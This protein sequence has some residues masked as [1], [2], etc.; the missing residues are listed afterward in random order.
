MTITTTDHHGGR[1]PGQF[2][3]LL[4]VCEGKTE[5]WG[6]LAG[7]SDGGKFFDSQLFAGMKHTQSYRYAAFDDDG[8]GVGWE[9]TQTLTLAQ[10]SSS[11]A[12][13]IW[14]RVVNNPALP[15]ENKNKQ[16]Y[17]F[18]VGEFVRIDAGCFDPKRTPFPSSVP[19][20]GDLA[21]LAH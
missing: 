2:D 20:I 13:L 5:V 7:E 14:T 6:R 15:T 16:W 17:S 10:L 11:A 8:E 4:S 12:R 18:G 9:E 21:S 3:A 1:K 19:A